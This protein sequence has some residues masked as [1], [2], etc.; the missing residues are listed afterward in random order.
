[1]LKEILADLYKEKFP[2]T[3]TVSVVIFTTDGGLLKDFEQHCLTKEI[4]FQDPL[5][6]FDYKPYKVKDVETQSI[7]ELYPLVTNYEKCNVEVLSPLLVS[8]NLIKWVFLLDWS[9]LTQGSWMRYIET[10]IS[11]LTDKG[12][13][14][15]NENVVI[16]CMNSQYMYDIQ[17][18]DVRWEPYHFDYLQQC[19]RS[20]VYYLNGSLVYVDGERLNKDYCKLFIDLCLHEHGMDTERLKDYTEMVKF[21]EICIPFGMDSPELIKTLDEK[22]EPPRIRN[23]GFIE[24]H[25]ERVIPSSKSTDQTPATETEGVPYLDIQKE[26]KILYEESKQKSRENLHK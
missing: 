8:S 6:S 9:Q 23:K 22:F 7:L 21:S 14:I 11:D 5:V 19:L 18:N 10:Q 15:D 4:R 1:M 17:R 2:K 20:Q 24:D 13:T 26:L 16:F 25:Y 12:Y 3:K